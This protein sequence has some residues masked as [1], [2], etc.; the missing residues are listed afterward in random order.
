MLGRGYDQQLVQP[1][2]IHFGEIAD[3]KVMR[4]Y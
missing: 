3:E 1:Q 4:V 2:K